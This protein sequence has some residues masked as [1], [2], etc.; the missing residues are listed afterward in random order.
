MTVHRLVDDAL[1]FHSCHGEDRPQSDEGKVLATA[2]A[3]AHFQSDFYA[4]M[5]DHVFK[6]RGTEAFKHW[7]AEKIERD[8]HVKI[9]YDD[10]RAVVAP[11]YKKLQKQFTSVRSF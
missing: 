2:D 5:Q 10:Q 3:R 4:Y 9:F 1:R 8:Y 11:T 7:A 6:D